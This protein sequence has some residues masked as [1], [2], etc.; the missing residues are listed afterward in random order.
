MPEPVTQSRQLSTTVIPQQF[1]GAYFADTMGETPELTGTC[2]A[3]RVMASALSKNEASLGS[4]FTRP[5]RRSL[6]LYSTSS[7]PL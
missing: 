6:A 4:P 7:V 5:V 3:E 2:V 1:V